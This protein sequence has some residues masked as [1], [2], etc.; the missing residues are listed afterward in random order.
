MAE[1]V[2]QIV[3]VAH[4]D[5]ALQH[6]QLLGEAP[7]DVQRRRA[8]VQEH[9]APH[10][11][12]GGGDPGEVAKTGGGELDHLAAGD[13][14]QMVGDPDHGVG[15]DMGHMAGHRQHQVVVRR[16]H[17]VDPGPQPLPE[18]LQPV[19]RLGVGPGQRRQ[20]APAAVEQ[21]G[22][23]RFRT[24][25]FGPRDRVGGHEMHAIGQVRRDI[26]DQ[27]DLDRAHVRD[28][29]AGLQRRADL[30]RH[31]A[32][33]ADRHAQDH[34]VGPRRRLRRALADP[35]AEAQLQRFGP[36]RRGARMAGD[37]ARQAA[38]LRR[39]GDRRADQ[40]EPDQGQLCNHR[41]AHDPAPKLRRASAT[42]RQP[43]SSPIEIRRCPGR[44]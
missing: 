1:I 15:D 4:P 13:P 22:K 14:A 35:V 27:A 10:G 11:R 41:A 7:E 44:P 36:R 21:L 9:V 30:G 19:D 24:R 25:V 16:L 2:V 39:P 12:V 23:T 3:A 37:L 31:R 6:E 28:D 18:G 34:Q 29:G 20:D 43:T 26:G 32:A 38:A 8:V 5:R 42:A 33:N 17:P 40:A